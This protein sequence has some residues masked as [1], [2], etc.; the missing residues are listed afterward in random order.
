VTLSTGKTQ[1][2]QFFCGCG[3]VRIKLGSFSFNVQTPG[4]VWLEW[5][6]SVMLIQS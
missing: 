4:K 5:K 6:E 3:I 2:G 1:S